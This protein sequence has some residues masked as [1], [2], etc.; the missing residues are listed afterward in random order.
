MR[1][2]R[3]LSLVSNPHPP[4]LEPHDSPVDQ[5]GP[6]PNQE[7]RWYRVGPQWCHY[8]HL[9]SC[10]V[11]HHAHAGGWGALD[12]SVAAGHQV[13][14]LLAHDHKLGLLG[15]PPKGPDFTPPWVLPGFFFPFLDCK[16]KLAQKPLRRWVVLH[17]VVWCVSQDLSKEVPMLTSPLLESGRTVTG[18]EGR[19]RIPFPKYT[20]DR[21][22]AEGVR[23]VLND[24][25]KH[26]T[27]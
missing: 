3:I 2:L 25:S 12:L 17:K 19:R 16:Q 13:H 11:H 4:P 24:S 6:H 18:P 14:H 15:L 20:E 21:T 1:E 22:R 10:D 7:S 9:L 8:R 23:P 5:S 26:V 27:G